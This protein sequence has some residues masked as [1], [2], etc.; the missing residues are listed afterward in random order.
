MTKTKLAHALGISRSTLYEYLLFPDHPKEMTVEAWKPF[1]DSIR[2]TPEDVLEELE[3]GDENVVNESSK[4]RYDLARAKMYEWRQKREEHRF[5]QEIGLLI[6]YGESIALM[7]E[8]VGHWRHRILQLDNVLPPLLVG[9]EPAEIQNVI[10]KH[11]DAI[12]YDAHKD[13]QK[14]AAEYR[15]MSEAEAAAYVKESLSKEE[16]YH[17]VS[18]SQEALDKL[19]ENPGTLKDPTPYDRH[20]VVIG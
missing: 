11:V 20:D 3:D 9:L 5:K 8:T 4:Q 12:L 14:R 16:T 7:K 17:E 18:V 13:I 2:S 19:K 6:P 1:I 15:K 10:R